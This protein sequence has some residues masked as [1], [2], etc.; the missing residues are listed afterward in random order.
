[1][2]DD[3]AVNEPPLAR[4]HVPSC[5]ISRSE[6][7]HGNGES[8][9]HD[10]TIGPVAREIIGHFKASVEAEADLVAVLAA[11]TPTNR[12]LHQIYRHAFHPLHLAAIGEALAC[13]ARTR[14]VQLDAAFVPVIGAALRV[15]PPRPR[16]RS[17]NPNTKD[18]RE[19]T[20]R[21]GRHLAWR[22]EWAFDV[23]PFD[24]EA[25]LAKEADFRFEHREAVLRAAIAEA[26]RQIDRARKDLAQKLAAL[27]LLE[28][29]TT[30][31]A[32]DVEEA[33]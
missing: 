18:F 14:R 7:M 23:M 16:R 28:Q 1:M 9:A 24:L 2:P 31:Q 6:L 13:P 26:R 17:V 10:F 32:S 25:E 29:E 3:T 15:K 30:V 8:A 5:G 21:I 12:L 27:A 19:F 20:D 33:A 22:A 4:W 11:A